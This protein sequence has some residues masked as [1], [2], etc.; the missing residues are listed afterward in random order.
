[1]PLDALLQ[2]FT[3]LTPESLDQLTAW[4]APDARF[5]DPF[6]EVTGTTH[7][8]A[9]FAHMFVATDNPRFVIHDTLA[10]GSQAFVTWTF[11][12]GLRGK[13]YVVQGA[14]HFRFGDDGRIT[15]HRD[16]WDAAEEL[17][18]KLPLVGA[19]IRW[20]RRRLAT[21]LPA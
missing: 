9:I 10:E 12:F 14:T 17:L 7:I 4:Y 1:M 11:H 8:H 13:A 6:N 21:P 3:R 5:K 19:P 16:Y 2:W 20:L 18:Q 15:E